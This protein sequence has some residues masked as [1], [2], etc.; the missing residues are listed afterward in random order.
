MR[1]KKNDILNNTAKLLLSHLNRTQNA[2]AL[3]WSIWA[4]VKKIETNSPATL[5][6]VSFALTEAR[7][8]R[9]RA[10]ALGAQLV[11]CVTKFPPNA[12]PKRRIYSAPSNEWNLPFLSRFADMV[13]RTVEPYSNNIARKS[14][15]FSQCS[16][17]TSSSAIS[18]GYGI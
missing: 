12:A 5:L 15:Y 1:I 4:P 13:N 3:W 17:W 10:D 16:C 11:K 14:V 8:L 9:H 7:M 6:V 2:P 18:C